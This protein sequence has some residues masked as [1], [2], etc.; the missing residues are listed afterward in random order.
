MCLLSGRV[1]YVSEKGCLAVPWALKTFLAYLQEVHF[2]VHANHSCLRWLPSMSEPSKRL[3]PWRLRLAEF[4]FN[5]KYK[6]G[7]SDVHAHALSWFNTVGETP[8]D[9]ENKNPCFMTEKIPLV[10]PSSKAEHVFD[11][12]DKLILKLLIAQS[13]NTDS[14]Q[15]IECFSLH[16]LLLKPTHR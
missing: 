15:Q 2:T 14:F 13:T 12:E 5:V 16:E 9:I 11:D 4:D 7:R 8:P 3:M 10:D 1:Q 6:K